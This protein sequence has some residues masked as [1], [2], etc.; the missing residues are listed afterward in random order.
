MSRALPLSL[1]FVCLLGTIGVG[2]QGLAAQGLAA[3]DLAR[4]S[5]QIR[6]END[7]VAI[8][9]VVSKTKRFANR[10]L[11]KKIVSKSDLKKRMVDSLKLFLWHFENQSEDERFKL[12]K[13]ERDEDKMTVAKAVI[14]RFES[15]VK[16][17]DETIEFFKRFC[18]S[19]CDES[20]KKEVLELIA[21]RAKLFAT[22]SGQASVNEVNRILARMV[23][24]LFA[25]DRIATDRIETERTLE[26]EPV[27]APPF[28]I[29]ESE[30]RPL[31]IV[32][33][34]RIPGTKPTVELATTGVTQDQWFQVMGTNPSFFSVKEACPQDYVEVDGLGLCK[35]YPVESV[36]Q[37]LLVAFLRRW[38][39]SGSK[40]DHR[41]PKDF[42]RLQA[43]RDGTGE[44]KPT[45]TALLDQAWFLTNSNLQTHRVA[46]KKANALGFFDLHG[47]LWEVIENTSKNAKPGHYTITGGSWFDPAPE[48][49]SGR[50]HQLPSDWVCYDVGFRMARVLRPTRARSL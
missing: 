29:L 41:I 42:E 33:Y 2:A 10:D 40:Y 20:T 15:Q 36:T 13:S 49:E 47:G 34:K 45:A 17:L 22:Q 39:E 30:L 31:P 24:A 4:S 44:G 28:R 38:N 37:D 32:K 25:T 19:H 8:S 14:R 21:L 43:T 3:S 50:A 27:L 12:A 1:A 9:R 18:A 7:S 23:E 16:R 11:P 46:L 26:I 5:L 35:G 6:I 48:L